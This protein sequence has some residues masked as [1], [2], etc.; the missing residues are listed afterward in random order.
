MPRH[1]EAKEENEGP[2]SMLVSIYVCLWC[3]DCNGLCDGATINTPVPFY[4]RYAQRR[5]H[6]NDLLPS[7]KI[8]QKQP[9]PGWSLS[10]ASQAC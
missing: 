10:L 4:V 2:L 6:K 8:K 7:Q 3:V 1:E 5:T 9:L